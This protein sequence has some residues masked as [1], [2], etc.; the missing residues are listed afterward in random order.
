MV[1][2]PYYVTIPHQPWS[3]V[4]PGLWQGGSERAL[5][6]TDFDA[7]LTMD[8][9]VDRALPAPEGAIHAV[10]DIE[11]HLMPDEDELI[12]A[13]ALVN[14]WRSEG[15]KVLVRCAAGLNRSGLVVATALLLE[16]TR[17]PREVVQLI[18]SKR[19]PDALCN[20]WF[21]AWILN[22]VNW[23]NESA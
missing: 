22:W 20:P 3:E 6:E 5:N 11:D 13:A 21:E 10:W 15:K 17:T 14:V 9:S 19:S 12:R 2:S 23:E 7:V 18:R 4:V 8:G 1:D 16:A